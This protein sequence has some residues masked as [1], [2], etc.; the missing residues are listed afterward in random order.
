MTTAHQTVEWDTTPV[1]ALFGAMSTVMLTVLLHPDVERVG[2][3]ALLTQLDEGDAATLSRDKPRFGQPR[4]GPL[5]PLGDACLSR[6]PVTLSPARHGGVR[7]D[8]GDS[9]TKV[10]VENKLVERDV[11]WTGD[12]LRRG[13]V[14]RLGGQVVLLLQRVELSDVRPNERHGLVGESPAIHRAL[15]EIESV[16]DLGTPVLVR[17]ETGTG[18]DLVARAIHQA[19]PRRNGPFLAVNLAAVPPS[20]AAAE[21]FGVERGA[22]TGAFRERQGYFAMAQG[23][24]LFL[25]E[26]GDAPA[27]VQVMLLR[28]IETGEVQGVGAGRPQ[29]VGVRL[30]AA[31]DADLEAKVR[32]GTFRGPLLH[33]LAAHE[34]WMRPLRERRDDIARLLLHFLRE[35]LSAAG[36]LHRLTTPTADGR[37]WLP[38]SLLARLVELDWSGNVRQLRNVARQIVASGRDAARVDPGPAL[39]RLLDSTPSSRPSDTPPPA[40]VRSDRRRPAEITDE[41]LMEAL[42]AHRWDLSAAAAELRIP[43]PSLYMLIRRNGRLRTAGD[44]SPEEIARSF[45][46]C[47]GDVGRMV[48]ALQVSEPALRRRIR[49]LGV[50]VG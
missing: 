43:R 27:D 22:F 36:A 24:T 17:G 34:I 46:A 23:G 5:R 44:L 30:V 38:A 20:L 35:E 6:T 41:E 16:A 21:L 49:E 50:E 42:R 48:E 39:E 13:V 12:A 2:E 47:G 26:I 32:D 15:H 40:A 37:S 18:K 9:R 3:R 45:E 33:R 4:G 11:T 7:L 28:A 8:R 29:K 31:T 25:D 10:V 19:G 1:P 14:L